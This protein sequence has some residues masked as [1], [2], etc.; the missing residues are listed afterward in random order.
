MNFPTLPPIYEVAPA[1]GLG[2]NLLDSII[3]S[4]AELNRR[5]VRI[6]TKLVCLM[7]DHGLDNRGRPTDML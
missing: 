7:K 4:L 3:E 2:P 6:E 5:Q 1:P